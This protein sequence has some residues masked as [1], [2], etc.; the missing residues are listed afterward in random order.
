MRLSFK[1]F[2]IAYIMVLL[3]T[4][5][6][7]LVLI[8]H[9]TDTLWDARVHTVENAGVYAVDSFLAFAD[10]MPQTPSVS[11]LSQMERQIGNTLDAS[12]DT[13]AIRRRQ[14]FTLEQEALQLRDNEGVR[15]FTETDGILRMEMTCRVN[16]GGDVYLVS[17]SSDLTQLRRQC[18][19]LWQWY[20]VAVLCLSVAS[21]LLIYWLT[22]TVTR[23]LR[24]LSAS[25][26]RI[27]AGEYGQTVAI[28]RRDAE[29]A[30][31]SESF[32][33]MSLTVAQKIEEI[34]AEVEKRERFVADFAHEMKTPMTAIIGYAQMLHRYELDDTER[35]EAAEAIYKEG[36]RLEKLSLQMLDWSVYQREEVAPVPL[37]LSSVAASLEQTLRMLSEK[38][39]LPFTL[40]L[41]EAVV[42][43]DEVL[44]LS[45]LYNLA[46][47]AFKA[48]TTAGIAVYSEAHTDGI[49]LCVKD[50]G[51]GIAPENIA[52]L[53]E[54]FFREDK[55]RSRALGG[56]GLGLTIC[57]QIA[58]LHGTSLRFDSVQG[59]GTVVSFV[60]KKG[61]EAI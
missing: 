21:G 42:M 46:D 57:K 26:R 49:A 5:L 29:I 60:L 17:V 41:G 53:T 59:A 15:R 36:K 43:A 45:L 47:N 34:T 48:S 18:R 13:V 32:N 10:V 7:G 58:A 50:R 22:K 52:R 3:S 9:I 8:R 51:N 54:P 44:L 28:S 39:R 31:L 24:R 37:S 35:R 38:Y 11:Q 56:A 27:A 23:P 16:T 20:G 40:A 30:E 4:G 2:A 33:G 6:G 55:S 25:A 12:I 14:E 19:T 61:G 1:F